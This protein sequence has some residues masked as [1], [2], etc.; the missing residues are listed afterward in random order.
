MM[1]KLK[2]EYPTNK[3]IEE[4]LQAYRNG[5]DALMELIRKRRAKMRAAEPKASPDQAK[6]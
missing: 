2:S 4:T 6:D 1:E 3:Q 5:G